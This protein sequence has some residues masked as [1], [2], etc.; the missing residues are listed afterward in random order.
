MLSQKWVK[1]CA[2]S[3]RKQGL[4]FRTALLEH[5][6]VRGLLTEAEIDALLDPANYLG[7]VERQIASVK[8]SIKT[9][10]KDW[11]LPGE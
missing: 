2:T 3:A 1:E 6:N 11:E 4:P 5:P 8:A 9:R 7:T 10:R